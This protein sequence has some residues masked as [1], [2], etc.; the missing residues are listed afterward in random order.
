MTLSHA[1]GTV[2]ILYAVDAP[3]TGRLRIGP[4]YLRLDLCRLPL[5][6]RRRVQP[7]PSPLR[8]IRPRVVA[9]EKLS[10]TLTW[11]I[12]VF[13]TGIGAVGA[14]VKCKRRPDLVTEAVAT[15]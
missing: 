1:L 12:C 10:T 5:E 14:S 13:T 3:I 4:S 8:A 6:A 7:S 11:M 2:A 15:F 9:Y